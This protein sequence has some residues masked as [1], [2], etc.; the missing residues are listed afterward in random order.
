MLI[1]SVNGLLS[2]TP[3]VKGGRGDL[4]PEKNPQS[5][6]EKADSSFTK[7]LTTELLFTEMVRKLTE[8]FPHIASVYFLENTG[9]ADIVTGNPILLSGKPA[10]TEELLGLTF[11]IQ[12][13]SFFQVNTLG[14]EKLYTRA[15]DFIRHK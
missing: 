15:I 8:K 5:A 7:E 12:P 1:F 14:A 9:R 3:F 2:Q 4:I 10:I 13:K 6:T 11:E